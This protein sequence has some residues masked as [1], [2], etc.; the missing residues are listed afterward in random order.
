MS[1]RRQNT[2]YYESDCKPDALRYSSGGYFNVIVFGT[3]A[4]LEQTLSYS[5]VRVYLPPD[6]CPDPATLRLLIRSQLLLFATVL[7]FLWAWWAMKGG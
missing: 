3:Y 4:A 6:I 1:Y 5:L 2:V 7:R